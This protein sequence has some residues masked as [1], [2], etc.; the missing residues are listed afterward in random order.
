MPPSSS[1]P[2][3]ETRRRGAEWALAALGLCLCAALAIGGTIGAA[4][5]RYRAPGPLPAARAV[6]IPA[7]TTTAVAH[8][9]AK[10]GVIRAPRLFALAALATSHSGPLHAAELQFPAHA[11]FATVL[12]ILRTAPPVEH[13]LT[14]P[15]GL[16]AQQITALLSLAPALT[17][18]A[19][20]PAEGCDPPQHVRLPLR[21]PP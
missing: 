20:L 18:P 10:A 15:E 4:A 1:A 14:I 2:P 17:G 5:W 11:S 21:H 9:L 7:G 12:A 8:A 16:T 13:R 3:P 19:H 6:V